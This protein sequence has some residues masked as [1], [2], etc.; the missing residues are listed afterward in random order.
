MVMRQG[1]VR[2]LVKDVLWPAYTAEK[3]HLDVIDRWVRWQHD[4]PVSPKQA[5]REHKE[6]AKRAQTPLGALIVT[7]ATQELYA[8]GYRRSDEDATA[9]ERPWYLWQANGMD[10]RQSAIYR[11]ALGYGQAY[12]KVLPG[13]TTLGEAIPVMR[14]VSPR[15]MVAMWEDP[16]ED[17]WPLY[18]MQVDPTKIGRVDGWLLRVYD[19]S[20]EYRLHLLVGGDKVDFVT[21][22][23][24]DVGVCPIVRYANLLD[25]E[26]RTPGE[27]EPLIPVLGRFDQVTYDRMLVQ[28]HASWKVRFATG[29]AKPDAEELANLNITED[30]WR[31]R[32]ALNL[33]ANDIL[34]AESPEAKFGSLPETPPD[35]FIQTSK[36]E[37]SLLAAASQTPS[38][39]LMGADM[40][41]LSADALVAARGSL[42]RKVEERKH[43]FGH[44][45]EQM[46]RLA[47]R[48]AGY[49]D[50]AQDWGA[51][52]L[53]RD[54]EGRSLGQAADALGKLATMLGVPVEMLWERIP[55]WTQQDVERAKDMYER[56]DSLTAL[57]HGLNGGSTSFEATLDGALTG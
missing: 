30:E 41:N 13:R 9:D 16:A 1:V 42:A 27:V 23:E 24:H 39:E 57:I 15:R 54:T 19:D 14:G 51:Q 33:A 48:I 18:A 10:R 31:R 12:T 49:R 52:V 8:E 56:G 46:I 32:V 35:G 29:M 53:W 4:D 36:F 44:A 47:C 34:I 26:G 11:A 37:L 50:A 20:A 6:L 28:R 21:F 40:I 43:S 2:D 38:Y 5:T 17:D 3:E 55:G 25:L 22:S 45:N 7:A